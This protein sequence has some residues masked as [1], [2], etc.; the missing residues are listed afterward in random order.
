LIERLRSSERD[1]DQSA[2]EVLAIA[3]AKLGDNIPNPSS[4]FDPAEPPTQ[5]AILI[6]HLL[7]RIVDRQR[8]LAIAVRIV[9]EAQPLWLGAECLRWMKVTDDPEKESSNALSTQEL[10]EVRRALV[11]RVKAKAAAG[12]PL[13]DPANAK[14]SG[15]IHEWRLAEGRET[16]Q[17]HLLNVFARDPSQIPLFL[18]AFTGRAWGMG[19]LL[20][21]VS[22]LDATSLK[23]IQ[24]LIDL[25]VLAGLI[26][27]HCSGNF[28]SPEYYHDDAKPL[29]QRL[30]EQFMF[31]YKKW[32][33]QGEPEG[34]A[35]MDSDEPA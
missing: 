14:E 32:K 25:D 3:V 27:Q 10:E 31:V 9:D 20:P 22:D 30:P 5:A 35:A 26:R 12:A 7:R 33:T 13:F 18:Q 6:S 21:R 2:A 17:A 1:V 8:R 11:V 29:A 19:D 24:S 34:R 4:F 23:V 16:V 28:D 15:I